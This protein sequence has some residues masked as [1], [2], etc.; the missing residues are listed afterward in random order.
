MLAVIALVQ[1]SAMPLFSLWGLTPDLM[2][3]AVVSWS[4]LRGMD[5]GLPLALAGGMLLD[6]LS[7]GP[8]GLATLS[9]TVAA[10]VTSF[11]QSG[12]ARESVW[13]PLVAGS[14]ATAVYDG[15]YLVILRLLGRPLSWTLGLVHVILPSM[16]WNVLMMYPAYWLLRR[17][18]LRT[19]PGRSE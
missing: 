18:H 11:G 12:I 3:L 7:G 17:L 4:L 19:A 9:L 16:V 2:L 14:L 5:Q 6:L 10:A 1:T 15:V 13:L 8:F